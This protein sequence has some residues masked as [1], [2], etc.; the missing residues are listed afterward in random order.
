[1]ATTNAV[2]YEKYGDSSV[3]QYGS[4]PRPEVK[5]DEVLIAVTAAGVNPVDYKIRRGYI[6]GWPQSFP[7]I[8][9]WD[10]AGVV[11][12]AGA[13]CKR[14]KVG[15]SV[16]S[17][18]RPEFLEGKD[19][20]IGTNGC[21]SEFVAAA[22][23]KVAKKPEGLSHI[24]A[25][26]TPLAALTAYQGIFEQG[27][28]K[29]GQTLLVLNASGGVGSF[30][31]QFARARGVTVIGTCSSR[32]I[33]LVKSLGV[34]HVIDYTKGD[35]GKAV[36]D[37][38]PNGVDVVFDCVGGDNIHAGF[39][40]MKDDGILVTIVEFTV[41]DIAKEKK[42]TAKV[43]VVRPSVEHLD[44]IGAWIGEGKVKLAKVE[45]LSLKDAVKAQ[46]LSEAHRVT[47]KLVLT[48]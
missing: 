45:T 4:R 8:P 10:V 48:P 28:L 5:A 36:R 44:A 7:I 41:A 15:D 3:L 16:W 22:E 18:N 38:F 47:G 11:V 33:E 39:A 29:E 30:A 35:V 20:A 14:L 23:R 9:G 12:E 40:A 13:D 46:D 1:M 43:F 17:Y 32:N 27:E 37:L 25:G 26:A 34:D 31:V 21:Y 19:E 24:E 6:Q 42:K 2:T